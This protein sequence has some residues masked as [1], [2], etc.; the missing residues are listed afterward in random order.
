[1]SVMWLKLKLSVKRG[2]RM[3]VSASTLQIFETPFSVILLHFNDKCCKLQKKFIELQIN[4]TKDY[5]YPFC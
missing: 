3:L 1:M 5:I 4:K 2:E